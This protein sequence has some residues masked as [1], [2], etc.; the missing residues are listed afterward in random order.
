MSDPP[1]FVPRTSRLALS[2]TTPFT[3]LLPV[4]GA[5]TSHL[6]LREGWNEDP[7]RDAPLRHLE[8]P[9][10]GALE[11]CRKGDSWIATVVEVIQHE[12]DYVLVRDSGKG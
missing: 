1:F 11:E 8:R 2:F 5:L 3:T 10:L 7:G 9:V 4:G 12:A 6:S